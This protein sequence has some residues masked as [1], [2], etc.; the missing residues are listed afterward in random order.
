MWGVGPEILAVIAGMLGV[1]LIGGS[2]LRAARRRRVT[3]AG[4]SGWAPAVAGGATLAT[5]APARTRT[6]DFD[7]WHEEDAAP[8]PAP[9]GAG[10]PADLEGLDHDTLDDLFSGREPSRAS[11]RRTSGRFGAPEPP[12]SPLVPD[13]RTIFGEPPVPRGGAAGFR[14]APRRSGG[15]LRNPAFRAAAYAALG[16]ALVVV[17]VNVALSGGTGGRSAAA[18]ARTPA[19]AVETPAAPAGPTPAEIAAER[20]AFTAS[21]AA[22]VDALATAERRA[23]RTERRRAAARRRLR[24]AIRRAKA[25][26]PVV[27]APGPGPVLV[28]PEPDP[29]ISSGGGDPCEFGCIG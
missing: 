1:T 13:A 26:D 5:A 20:D 4:G 23:R 29:N 9:V 11:A 6:A 17:V 19:A 10:A 25:R 27:P 14:S 16:I 18:P 2:R 8:R 7:D 3:R 28:A 24:A 22:A 12:G 21:R 15:L